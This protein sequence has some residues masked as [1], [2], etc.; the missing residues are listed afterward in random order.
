MTAPQVPGGGGSVCVIGGGLA[1]IAAAIRLADQGLPVTLLES[2][3]EL[4]GATYSFR[5]DGLTVDTGQHVFLRCYHAYRGLLDRLGVTD[6]AQVQPRFAVPVLLPGRAPHLLARGRLPAPAHLLP[7]LAAYRLLT[8]AER[9]AAVRA[10]AALRHVDP[11]LP[12]TDARSFGEW[13]AGHGQG[14][15]AVRRLWDLVTVAALNLPSAH[16][17]LALAAR[18]FRTGLLDA[19][20]AGD[21]G[22]PTVPLTELHAVPARRLLHQLGARVRTRSRVRWIHP[23]SDG[24][25]VG[26]SDG[27]IATD[28]VVLAVPH[29]VAAALVPPAAAP[30]AGDWH[31]LGAAPIV[32][33]HLRY[34]RRITELAM[35]AA[36]ESPAQWI[37]TRPGSDDA[38]HVV[39]SLSAADTQIDRPAAELVAVQ[40]AALAALFPAARHTPVRDAF[41][42]RE[43]RATFRQ[44]PGT[45]A[46]RPAT[47]TRLPGLVLAGAWTDTGWPDTMEG[48]VRSGQEAADVV[49]RQ[50]ASRPRHHTEA[51]R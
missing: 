39:V 32:N 20:D 11:D 34:A 22:R 4:G 46:Y 15:R 19:T 12:A 23:E 21:I 14:D 28:A 51:A 38:Q 49:A 48:A 2:R 30:D 26:L 18:V 41:V 1:G 50:L 3:P 33:V 17:S 25:R 42:T 8:P 31:R 5:R 40:R 13:L 45:R 37:F 29:H 27:E 24:F 47:T 36:V 10:A 35:A 43:P 9:L 6:D 7:A 44:A 16:A